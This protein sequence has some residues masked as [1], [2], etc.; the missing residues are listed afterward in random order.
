M[1][2]ISVAAISAQGGWLVTGSES[3]DVLL[4]S[5]DKI[6]RRCVWSDTAR[7][8]SA[9]AFA[10]RDGDIRTLELTTGDVA[11]GLRLWRWVATSGGFRG[12]GLAGHEPGYPITA[13]RYALGGDRILSASQ[14]HAVSGWGCA[15]G[16]RLAGLEL[17]HPQAVRA[18]MEVAENGSLAC[19]LCSPAQSLAD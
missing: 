4:W 8:V 10:R 16:K 1:G 14:D 15:T 6:N 7:Q 2:T 9:A 13:V 12:V 17:R 5:L 3:N 11:G 19:T 18:V